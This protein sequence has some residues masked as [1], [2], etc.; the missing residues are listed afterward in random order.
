MCLCPYTPVCAAEVLEHAAYLGMAA[1]LVGP[2]FSGDVRNP[3][4]GKGAQ[5]SPA[6][7]QAS[8]A[9]SARLPACSVCANAPVTTTPTTPFGPN[10]SPG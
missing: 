1:M 10:K 3:Q 9:G 6:K 5:P 4:V 2:L 7:W 8:V